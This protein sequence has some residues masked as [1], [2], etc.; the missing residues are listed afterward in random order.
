M[1]LSEI[2]A[3]KL[4]CHTYPLT[5]ASQ[6]Q[7][8]PKGIPPNIPVDKIQAELSAPEFWVVKISQITK[9]DKTT[10]TL[11]T[12]YS[13]FVVTFQPGTDVCEVLEI[14]KVCHCIIRWEKYKNTKPV[15]Q[16]FNCQ[17]FGHSSNFCGK[18]SKC[19]KVRSTTCNAGKQKPI[20]TPPK[21]IDCGGTHP[22]NF[23][24]CPSYQKLNFLHQWQP[25]LPKPT[26]PAF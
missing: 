16:C 4:A 10:Q 12:K 3:P 24:N 9:T 11:V 5:D 20:G 2:Q 22:A 8:V 14:K 26:T 1:L 18:P 15:R 21:C 19:V 6:L 17:S 25:H 23:T 13:V 7:L